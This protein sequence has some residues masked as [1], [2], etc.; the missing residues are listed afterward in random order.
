MKPVGL[1][2]IGLTRKINEDYYYLSKDGLP[3][4]CVADGVGGLNA[5]ETASFLAVNSSVSVLRRKNAV[6]GKETMTEAFLLANDTVNKQSSIGQDM[7]DMGTTLSCAWFSDGLV[8]IGHVGDSR[9]YLFRNNELLRVSKDH[10]FVEEL[11]DAGTITREQAR[12]H[13]KRNIITRCIGADEKIEPQVDILP[14]ENGDIWL[15]CSDG[16]TNY[17]D[18][19]GIAVV[20]AKSGVPLHDRI[21]ELRDKAILGG[22]RDNITVAAFIT[23]G[24]DGE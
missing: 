7:N 16:L 10:S 24:G 11:V 12:N 21:T 5:G 3:L 14:Y 6:F 22:G 2:D 1:T 15:L 20:L 18:D 13:P 19:S 9:I 17:V 4:I 23:G 8:C